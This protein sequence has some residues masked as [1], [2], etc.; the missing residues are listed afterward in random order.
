MRRNPARVYSLAA[1]LAAF[2]GKLYPEIPVEFMVILVFALLGIGNQVQ[3]V[4]D[5][6]TLKAL[7]MTPPRKRASKSKKSDSAGTSVHSVSF[8]DTN[9]QAQSPKAP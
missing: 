4:E 2:V 9:S 6:K 3:K 8:S 5:R 7:Y 1:A